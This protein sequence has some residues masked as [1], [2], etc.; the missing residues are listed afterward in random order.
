[1]MK[2]ATS[3]TE[4]EKASF[5]ALAA[6]IGVAKAAKRAKVNQQTIR[7]WRARLAHPG[8]RDVPTN[9]HAPGPVPP[10]LKGLELLE[11]QAEALLAGVRAMRAAHRQVFGE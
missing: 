7:N 8:E 3:Y 5:V 1:M 6:G 10:P 2:G 9:G 4:D 11:Q